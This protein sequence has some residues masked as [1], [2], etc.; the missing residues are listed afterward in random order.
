MSAFTLITDT[1]ARRLSVS[2]GVRRH[3]AW[4]KTGRRSCQ[5]RR[6]NEKAPAGAGGVRLGLLIFETRRAPRPLV[7]GPIDELGSCG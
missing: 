7:Q 6:P 1:T 3:P 2:L 5:L 4:F